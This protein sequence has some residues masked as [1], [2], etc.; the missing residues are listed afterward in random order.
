VALWR[1]CV[2]LRMG[3]DTLLLAAWK[4][5]V[6]CLHLDKDVELS[7]PPAPCLPAH[8]HASCNDDNGLNL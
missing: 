7:A 1:K 2:I 6:F 5:A 4:A 8:C 3:F